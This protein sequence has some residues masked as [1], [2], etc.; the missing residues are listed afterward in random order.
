LLLVMLQRILQRLVTLPWCCQD[1]FMFS[2]TMRYNLDPFGIHADASLWE[3]LQEVGLKGVVEGLEGA[4]STNV[5][6]N[7]GNFSQV[8]LIQHTAALQRTAS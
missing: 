8:G 4:L 7:G 2:G 5:A 3:V 1:P 6:D